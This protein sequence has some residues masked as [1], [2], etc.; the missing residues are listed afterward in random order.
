MVK[1]LQASCN[2]DRY[3]AGYDIT[4]VYYRN[5]MF[6]Y[7]PLSVCNVP[8]APAGRVN[9]IPA[10]ISPWT[11]TRFSWHVYSPMPRSSVRMQPGKSGYG[12]QV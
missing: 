3:A 12:I 11:K 2:R 9:I 6:D 1:N 4:L 5:I 8:R 7:D 10:I